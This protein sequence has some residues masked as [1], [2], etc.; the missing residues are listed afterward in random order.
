MRN[1]RE[2]GWEKVAR[3]CHNGGRGD[4]GDAGILMATYFFRAVAADGKLRTGTLHGETDKTVARDLRRQGLTPVYVGAEPKK[5]SIEIKL[6]TFGRRPRGATCCSSPR[7][8]PRCLN[9]GVPLDRALSITGELYRT[10]GLPLRRARYPAC[11]EGRQV[12]R[13][14]PGDAPGVF[15]GP[16]RQHGAG[17]RGFGRP[18]AWFSSAWPNSSARATNCAAISSR[19]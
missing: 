7:S 6:P 2:D 8:S 13:R 14:Q 4:A 17:G 16:V 10:R 9:A 3:G 12:A 15:L 1:L 18:G 5:G 19:R 11:S